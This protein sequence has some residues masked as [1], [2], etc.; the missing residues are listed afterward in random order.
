[1]NVQEHIDGIRGEDL[2][3]IERGRSRPKLLAQRGADAVLK[4]ILVDGF[5]HADPHPGNV[6]YP[7][8]QPDRDDRLRHG[9]AAGTDASQ[10]DRR[11]VSM[12]SR[13][14]T[15][16]PCSK[17]CSIGRGDEA[18]DEAQPR[19][20]PGELASDYADVALKDLA[21]VLCSH[22]WPPSC[23][24]RHRATG[25]PDADVQGAYHARGCQPQLRSRFP[26]DRTCRPFLE[27]AMVERYQPTV[28]LQR[29]QASSATSSASSPRCR[30]IWRGC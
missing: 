1:M 23:A 24:A 25:R 26:P 4:M 11:S 9:G 16:S 30:A 5:F 2:A 22:D 15:R 28:A 6:I 17:C 8:R 27:R 14:T 12:A 10:P 7:A 20:R 29:G 3:A 21:S 18:V 19:R 13:T